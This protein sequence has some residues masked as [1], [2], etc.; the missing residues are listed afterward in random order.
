VEVS[1][2]QEEATVYGSVFMA[3]QAAQGR[4]FA[5]GKVPA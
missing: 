1:V 3:L 5:R 2:L 4:L